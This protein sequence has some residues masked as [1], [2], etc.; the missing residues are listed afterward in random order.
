MEGCRVLIVGNSLFAEG[1]EIMIRACGSV[2]VDCLPTIDMAV[3]MIDQQPPDVL[4]LADVDV[5]NLVGN[6]PFLPICPDIPVICMDHQ[7][8]LLKLITSTNV[9]A[10]LPDLVNA[11]KLLKTNKLQNGGKQ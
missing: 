7:S 3:Q 2:G 1:V 11:L 6:T 4:I 5:I 8:Q 10:R 9:N